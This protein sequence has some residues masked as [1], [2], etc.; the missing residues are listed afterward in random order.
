[1]L[2]AGCAIDPRFDHHIAYLAD[3]TQL[4]G[5]TAAGRAADNVSYWD[6]GS[7]AGAPSIEIHLAEQRAYFFKGGVLVGVSQVSTGREGH[8]TPP[9]AYKIIQRDRDHRSSSYGDF[10]DANHPELVIKA[11]VSVKD[12]KPVG[13]AFLGAPMPN[14]MRLTDDGVGMHAGY[15]PGLPASHGCIRMLARLAQDFFD[16]APL[17]TSV[18]IKP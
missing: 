12:P 6:G 11:N 8:N 4:L 7:A 13:S 9:G 18:V 2:E 16:N 10:V 17:G 1:M 5:T 3:P 14:F 15:L